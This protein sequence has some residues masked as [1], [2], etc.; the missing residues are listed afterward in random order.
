MAGGVLCEAKPAMGPRNARPGGSAVLCP[1]Q[2]ATARVQQ[3]SDRKSRELRA[4]TSREQLG[5]ERR[6]FQKQS[7]K[8]SPRPL[9]GTWKDSGGLCGLPQRP[10]PHLGAR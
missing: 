6:S 4:G 8:R 7:L 2:E 5:P 9:W 3:D 1:Y 10:R